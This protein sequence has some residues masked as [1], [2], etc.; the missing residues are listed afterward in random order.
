M[1]RC[2]RGRRAAD[3]HANVD[4]H[5]DSNTVSD[6]PASRGRAT[7]PNNPN[8]YRDPD[9]SDS[10]RGTIDSIASGEFNSQSDW[11]TDAALNRDPG[12]RHTDAHA[13]GNARADVNSGADRRTSSSL[14][15]GAKELMQGL[16]RRPHSHGR[17]LTR[18]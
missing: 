8:G 1:F 6:F 17:T 5:V 18:K 11:H 14:K 9:S 10:C 16:S 3:A 15:L 12:P 2:R 13:S 7:N 4:C